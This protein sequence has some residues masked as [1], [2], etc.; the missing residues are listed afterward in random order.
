MRY[1][2]KIKT[3]DVIREHTTVEAP[4]FAAAL[5]A[6]CNAFDLSKPIVCEKHKAE[7]N[8]FSRTV[9]YPDDFVDAVNFDTLDIEI[10]SR[11][12]KPSYK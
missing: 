4:D 5:I 8:N 9:F 2:A 1:W 3:E 11:K 12:K 10:I 7:M 6:I